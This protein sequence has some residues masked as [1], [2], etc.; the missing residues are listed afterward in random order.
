MTMMDS[1]TPH[2]CDQPAGRVLDDLRRVGRREGRQVA[3][4]A[5]AGVA[6]SGFKMYHNS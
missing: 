3:A 1:N 5:S 2:A 4:E 6:R